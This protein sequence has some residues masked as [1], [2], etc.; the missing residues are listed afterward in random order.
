[1]RNTIAAQF[2]CNNL[3]WHTARPK[4]TPKET[5]GGVC[6]PSFLQININNLAILINWAPK[7]VLLAADLDE[8]LV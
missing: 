6:I 1:V 4:K 8:Y 2:V 3:P 7:V 5:F